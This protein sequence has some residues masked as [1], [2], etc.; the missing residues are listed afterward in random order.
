M[1]LIYH[2]FLIITVINRIN[3]AI[4]YENKYQAIAGMWKTEDGNTDY[5][6]GHEKQ[7]VYPQ[8]EDK[9]MLTTKST[10]DTKIG[11][12]GK[13]LVSGCRREVPASADWYLFSCFL[14]CFSCL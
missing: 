9:Y 3:S 7:P 4:F 1:K 2:S 8:R 10:K 14:S 13:T 12:K 5:P 11:N 6:D